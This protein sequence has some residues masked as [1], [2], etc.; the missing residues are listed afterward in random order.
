MSVYVE[1]AVL[2]VACATLYTARAPVWAY[3]G[4]IALAEAVGWTIRYHYILPTIQFFTYG[5]TALA[6]V[7]QRSAASL[8]QLKG[9]RDKVRE[10]LETKEPEPRPEE[11]IP[12]EPQADRAARFDVGDERAAQPAGEL[13]ESLGSAAAGTE[14][15]ADQTEKERKPTEPKKTEPGD[16]TSRLLKAKRRARDELEERGKDK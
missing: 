13:A 15:E 10:D 5:V 4:A 1:I 11:T 14:T 6:R 12:L 2:A 7:G 8:S 9:V 16:L 3:G